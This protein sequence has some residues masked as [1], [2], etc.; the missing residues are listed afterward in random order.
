MDIITDP[1]QRDYRTTCGAEVAEDVDTWPLTMAVTGF[2]VS[3]PG[4]IDDEL[5]AAR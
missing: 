1:T 4:Y 2:R 3:R 5:Q